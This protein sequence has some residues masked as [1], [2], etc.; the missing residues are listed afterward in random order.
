MWEAFTALSA[1][2]VRKAGKGGTIFGLGKAISMVIFFAQAFNR[3]TGANKKIKLT[4]L[5]AEPVPPSVFIS[6]N[7][8]VAGS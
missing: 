6:H 3:L 4:V 1:Q 7:G 5:D 2:C 8:S